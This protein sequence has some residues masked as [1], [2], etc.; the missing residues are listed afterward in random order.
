MT[1]ATRITFS[2]LADRLGV[3]GT[4]ATA[5]RHRAARSRFA[6]LLAERPDHVEAALRLA[7]LE[8]G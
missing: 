3:D 6:A 1:D 4:R 2:E 8:R 5:G 7:E